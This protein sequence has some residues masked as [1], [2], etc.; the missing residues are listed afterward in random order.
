M[1]PA[2]GG[3]QTDFDADTL[4][5]LL[6]PHKVVVHNND[7]NTFEEVTKVLM[8]AVPGITFEQAVAYTYEIHNTGAAVPYTGPKE[9][10]EAVAAVIRS[11]G[12]KVTVER[13]E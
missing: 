8:K 9:Q 5:R 7:F 4:R 1:E 3:V 2:P 11:I 6:P 12:I 13:D 10:A